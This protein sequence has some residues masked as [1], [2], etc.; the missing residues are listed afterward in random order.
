MV[1]GQTVDQVGMFVG[2]VDGWWSERH[3]PPMLVFI[4]HCAFHPG[5]DQL[6]FVPLV[7]HFADDVSE[8]FRIVLGDQR[9]TDTDELSDTQRA[10]PT[11]SRV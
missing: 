11:S 5:D 8:R 4:L 9:V 6:V 10:A 3:V 1:P 2:D 7:G